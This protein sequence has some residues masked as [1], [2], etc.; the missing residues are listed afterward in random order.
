VFLLRR[1]MFDIEFMDPQERRGMRAKEL[2]VVAIQLHKLG[3][4]NP[5]GGAIDLPA[6]LQQMIN[7]IDRKGSGDILM[8]TE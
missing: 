6:A 4:L 8:A 1:R 3:K 2:F 5:I 7:Y